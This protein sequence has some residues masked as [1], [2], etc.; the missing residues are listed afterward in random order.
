MAALKEEPIGYEAWS[1]S[2]TPI[3]AVSPDN[4]DII[5][6]SSKHDRDAMLQVIATL[7]AE[8]RSLKSENKQLKAK[9]NYDR[10][11]KLEETQKEPCPRKS[12]DSVQFSRLTKSSLNGIQNDSKAAPEA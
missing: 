4:P 1:R 6:D 2:N 9:L 12:N 10:Q 3:S 11:G 5:F 8:T 7:I